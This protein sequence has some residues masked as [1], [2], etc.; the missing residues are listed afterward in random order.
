MAK[1]STNNIPEGNYDADWGNDTS[2]GLPYSGEAVQKFIK[3]ELKTKVTSSELESSVSNQ[4]NTQVYAGGTISLVTDVSG[5]SEKLTITKRNSAGQEVTSDINIGTPD[6]NDRIITVATQ[7]SSRYINVGGETRL[8][9]GFTVEDYQ[10][11]PINNAFANVRLNLYRQGSTNP[12]YT[13]DLGSKAS[14]SGGSATNYELDITSIIADNIKNSAS[15]IATITV[16]HTY[17]YDVTD[18]S[19]NVTNTVTK[20]ITKY[21]SAVLTIL[22]L[23]LTTSIN[24][25]NT[26]ITG[27]YSIPY[28]V[29]GNGSKTVFLYH[30]GTLLQQHDNITAASSS[31][32]FVVNL[33]SGLNN[34]QIYAETQAD[35]TVVTSTSYYFDLF[36]PTSETVILFMVEDTTG[37]KQEGDSYLNPTFN[38]SKFSDYKFNYYV[39]NSANPTITTK[40]TTQELDTDGSIIV[41]S[42][43]EQLLDR[44]LYTYSK[45]IKTSN[46]IKVVFEAD[47]KEK[48]IIINPMQS[49]INIEIPTESIVFNLDADGRSNEEANPAVWTYRDVT[50]NFEGVNWESS[51]WIN[52]ALVLKN[53]AKAT[54]NFDLFKSVD[55]YPVTAK[56][57]SFEILFK[58]ENATLEENDIIS[59]YWN[60]NA[61]KKTGLNI[62]TSYVGVDTGEESEYTDD[63]GNVTSRVATRVGSQYNQGDYYKYVFV[64]DPNVPRNSSGSEKGVCYGYF[65]GIL[66]YISSIPIEFLNDG[67][68]ITIDSTYADVYVKSI[69]YYNV[70]L[71]HDECV[72]SYIID[73]DSPAKVEDLYKTND[74]LDSTDEDNPFIS[75]QKLHAMGRG[76]I[77]VS[78]STAQTTLTQLYD[79][80]K[81]SDKKSYFG[82]FR[83]AYFAP[84][85]ELDL[86]YG[87]VGVLGSAYNFLHTECAIRVQGTTSTKRPRKN[88]RFH[89]N[90]KDKESKP[91]SG[92]FI[93]GGEVRENFKYSMSPSARAVPIACLKVDYVDSSMT[94]NTGG[95]VVFNEMTKNVPSLRNEAQN[96]EMQ[97]YGE[98]T[99]RTSVQGFPVDIFAATGVVNP[100]Y[101]DTLE[102]SNYTGLVYMGQYNFNNDKSKSGNVF[103]FDGEY[104]YNDYTRD[105][106]YELLEGDSGTYQPICLEFLDNNTSENFE[107]ASKLAL[108]QVKFNSDQTIDEVSTYSISNFSKSLEVRAPEDMTDYVADNGLAWFDNIVEGTVDE[109]EQEAFPYKYISPQIK[110]LFNWIGEC[111]A[112]VAINAGKTPYQLNSFTTEQF[113]DLDWKSEKF[114]NEA[115]EYL[116]ISSICAW[117]IWTDYFLSIDQRAKNMMMYTMDGKHWKLQY[118]D[119]DSVLG[120]RNDCFLAYD[121]LT[122]RD[123]YDYSVGQYAFQGYNSWLWYLIRANLA[124]QE[125]I[126]TGEGSVVDPR[127]SIN[128]ESVCA[129]MRASGK[130]SADYIKDV[131]NTQFVSNWSQ[132]QYNYSQ[133]YKYISPLVETGYPSDIGTNYIITAQGSR[134][135]H[136]NFMLENRFSLLDSKYQAGGY[137]SDAFLYYANAASTNVLT[138]VSSIPYYFGWR[139]ANTSIKDHSVANANNNYTVELRITGNTTNN[140]AD[141]LGASRIKELT[142]ASTSSWVVDA[143]KEVKLANLQKL[144]AKNLGTRASGSLYLTECPLLTYLDLSSSEFSGL[145]GLQNC[146]KIVYIDTRNTKIPYIRIADGAPLEQLHLNAPTGIYLSNYDK[147]KFNESSTTDTLTVQN[148]TILNTL[149]VNNCPNVDWTKLMT[150]LVESTATTKYVRITGID[151]EGNITWLDTF[152]GMKGLDSNGNILDTNAQI[153]GTLTL[154]DYTDD[155][156]VATYK[157]KYPTMNIKQ[158]PFTLIEIDETV[159][160]ETYKG[161]GNA[162]LN[163]V[164]AAII[165]CIRNLDNNTGNTTGNIY[166]HSGHI[167]N[168]LNRCHRYLGKLTKIGETVNLEGNPND[169]TTP[170][171]IIGDNGKT[172]KGISSYGSGAGELLITQLYDGDSNYFNTG[173]SSTVTRREADLSGEFGSGEVGVRIPGFWYKGINWLITGSSGLNWSKKYIAFSSYEKEENPGKSADVDVI[174]IE[175]LQN[176]YLDIN[177]TTDERNGILMENTYI[178]NTASTDVTTRFVTKEGVGYNTFRIKVAGYKKMKFPINTNSNFSYVFVTKNGAMC[179]SSSGAT[180]NVGNHIFYGSSYAYSG[181][182]AIVNVPSDAYYF[183]MSYCKYHGVT[184]GT[185]ASSAATF[186]E[187]D[188]EDIILH[189]GSK[190]NSG[191]DMNEEN[192]MDWIADMEPEWL[193]SEPMFIHA[194]ECTT[195]GDRNLYTSFNGTKKAQKGSADTDQELNDLSKWFQYGYRRS[196]YIRG[197]QLIDYE[198][199][200][201]LAILFMAKY[202]RRSSQNQLGAGSASSDRYLGTTRAYGIQDTVLT[203]DAEFNSST[204]TYP[205]AYVIDSYK[206]GVPQYKNISSPNF[207]GIENIHGNAGEWLDRAYYANETNANKGK[208]RI[209]MPDM[210]TRRVYNVTP[211]GNYPRALVLGKYCDIISCSASNGSENTGYPD[212]SYGNSNLRTSWTNTSAVL[213]SIYIASAD[214]GVFCSNARSS[215][216]YPHPYFG[217]RLIF[218]GNIIETTDVDKYLTTPEVRPTFGS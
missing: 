14:T 186:V 171:D 69:K 159:T 108:F 202:G 63:D 13:T 210:S 87:T 117:Y 74:V 179:V 140:P 156:I 11:D 80:N 101:T 5:S 135:A 175:D 68:P 172:F 26:G 15:V 32:V 169:D 205:F 93:V 194:A 49:D 131:F 54:I 115:S 191:E 218:R 79:L 62:T 152:E 136:R 3:D 163:G 27:Q 36:T 119:G 197:L 153:I 71:S 90:K 8:A 137:T 97:K 133:E 105:E 18:E 161:D 150:R 180:E 125:Y 86:G 37:S 116:N 170:T 41:S 185:S 59:C 31:G 165:G 89:F 168:I 29:K 77:I 141:V 47:N 38:A 96:L 43:S 174:K 204:K 193:Y 21:G 124:R 50:T 151:V 73:Q 121:Y 132:R 138:I 61:G 126:N 53:G 109:D 65:N 146:S 92:S 67:V 123:T 20:T 56:G 130:F 187:V 23:T 207:L 177:D 72:N 148:W 51:G 144:V 178:S 157:A 128:L 70:P 122:D 39:Y 173:Y 46:T 76:V 42:V 201:I 188:P 45:R 88:W 12:F 176:V 190:Y 184:S 182:G 64:I 134:E 118:Y 52:N 199:S 129:L 164:S 111:A 83:I 143:S 155:A 209:T 200:K 114:L 58:C 181:M 102:D 110:R 94:H 104:S 139:T 189:R 33:S 120:E 208:L 142:F 7:L 75:P 85:K 48:Y 25:N 99:T 206:Q 147:L 192:V 162:E 19:G 95:A 216:G 145:N 215:V 167:T 211:S 149:Y 66:S 9:Y 203:A 213:R 60:N 17:T 106:D 40:I 113:E 158:P 127:T 82:P 98:I 112:E 154:R 44:K 217:S 91:A 35:D 10:G 4:I 183:Y 160:D 28:T 78:P 84:E 81:S 196:A 22:A 107:E 55:G 34:Y 24:I 214:G 100:A 57:C 1:Y 30:N 195:N 212:Y 103:G 166:S 6:V 16:S 198:A 2:V